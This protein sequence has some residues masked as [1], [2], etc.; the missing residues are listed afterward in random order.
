ML[1]CNRTTELSLFLPL[2]K[3]AISHL[4]SAKMKNG[5]SLANGR[6]HIQTVAN[7]VQFHGSSPKHRRVI[8]CVKLQKG[9]RSA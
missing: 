7:G 5:Q 9:R 8:H 1:K 4:S 6:K 2:E 3:S